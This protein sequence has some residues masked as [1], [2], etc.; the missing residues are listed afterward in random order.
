MR[1]RFV[2]FGCLL[3]A[4]LGAPAAPASASEPLWDANVKFL[5]LKVNRKGETLVSY[6]LPSGKLRNVLVWGAIN[7]RTPSET[8]PQVRFKWDYAGGWGKYRKG[9]YWRRF[10]DQ[11]RPYDGPKLAN[12]VAACKAPDGSYWAVQSWKR[13][14]PLLGFEPWAPE[15]RNVELHV[16]HWSGPIAELDV[17]P[18]WTYNGAWQ[19]VFGRYSYRGVPVYGFGATPKGIPTDKY[20]RNL[21]IDTL[22]SAYGTGWKRETGILTHRPT[23][24]FCHSFVPQRPL[25]SYPSQEVRPAAPGE[26]HRV[27]I[28]GPG[29]T[30]IVRVELDGLTRRDRGRDAEFNAIFDRVMAGDSICAPER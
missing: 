9:K 13:R 8:V 25:A 1:T 15:Q 30:P 12:L 21:Y 22:N 23:G 14:L 24:T 20:G 4:V 5:S 16:S 18:N 19:G 2:V 11:C 10:R 27:T 7:A 29:V 28:G 6:L 3:V 26:R 17:Y